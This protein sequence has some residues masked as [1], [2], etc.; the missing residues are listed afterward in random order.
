MTHKV[1]HKQ[2]V[3]Y[4]AMYENPTVIELYEFACM[5]VTLSGEQFS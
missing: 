2:L 3:Q 4:V 1:W 5:K